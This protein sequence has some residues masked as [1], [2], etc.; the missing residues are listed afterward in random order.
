MKKDDN[1]LLYGYG[2]P[3]AGYMPAAAYPGYAFGAYGAPYGA[4]GGAYGYRAGYGYGAAY[5]SPFFH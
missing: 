3:L 5:G 2:A 1:A 4:Y